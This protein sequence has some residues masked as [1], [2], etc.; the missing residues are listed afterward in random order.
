MNRHRHRY[1]EH[2]VPPRSDVRDS[3]GRLVGETADPGFVHRRARDAY[4]G[5]RGIWIDWDDLVGLPMEARLAIEVWAR[6]KFGKPAILNG[7]KR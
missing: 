5:Q 3:I 4:H 7:G 1:R 6:R 2:D